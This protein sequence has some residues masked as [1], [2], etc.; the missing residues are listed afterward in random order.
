M[1]TQQSF[2]KLTNI[3]LEEKNLNTQIPTKQFS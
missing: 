1:L 3:L 2:V